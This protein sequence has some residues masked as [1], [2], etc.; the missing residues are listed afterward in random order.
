MMKPSDLQTALA[1]ELAAERR[2]TTIRYS[3]TLTGELAE[4]LERLHRDLGGDAVLS[5]GDLTAR[6]LRRVLLGAEHPER[7]ARRRAAEHPVAVAGAEA[8]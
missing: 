5:R 7:R 8:P 1:A 6:L 3:V 4:A 2:E